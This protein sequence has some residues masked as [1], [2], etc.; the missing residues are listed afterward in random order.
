V[1]PELWVPGDS[2]CP[3]ET[4]RD[5]LAL[6]GVMVRVSFV[7][8]W[9]RLERIVAYDWAMREYLHASDNRVK[10]RERPSF[11]EYASYGPGEA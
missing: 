4:V 5:A 8:R 9:T 2:G 7:S 1:R 6:A 3:A 10:R 11:V